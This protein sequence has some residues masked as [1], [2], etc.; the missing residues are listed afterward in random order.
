[1]PQAQPR[2]SAKDLSFARVRVRKAR[3][4]AKARRSHATRR[5]EKA[6]RRRV[7][8]SASGFVYDVSAS[9]CHVCYRHA[10]ASER[11]CSYAPRARK[12]RRTILLL[13]S[14]ARSANAAPFAQ[15]KRRD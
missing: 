14:R 1:V 2:V 6:G 3:A 12:S 5:G 11:L 4:A 10:C 8:Y 7:W 15:D 9:R 13:Y